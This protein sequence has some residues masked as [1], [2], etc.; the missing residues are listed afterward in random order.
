MG[1]ID[2]LLTLYR[3]DSQV[4]GLR[5]RVD[6]AETY[7]R[8]QDRQLVQIKSDQEESELHIRQKEATASN[9]ETERDGYT[10]R[11]ERLR[12][13]LNSCTT[14]KQYSAVQTEMKSLKEQADELDTQAL[15]ILE[16]LDSAR[17]QLALVVESANERVT[18]RES[19]ATD[20][21]QR[22]VDVG[23]RL[24]ELE[25]ERSSAAA[26]VPE[27]ALT[28]F[29]KVADDTEGDTLCEVR[30]VSR[31]HREYA[32]GSC[33]M[34]LPFDAVVRLTNSNDDLV[35]CSGCYRI[36]YLAESI[37]GELAK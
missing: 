18:I 12:E 15:E 9:I 29:D 26:A 11:I 21:G 25:G 10:E 23:D 28:I 27:K 20:L 19:A 4:R 32:C 13:E 17:E 3:V 6:N 16:E 33:S 24:S 8:V 35:Q 14:S 2:Q 30:E 22:R 36:L 34:E 5:T 37:K 7:L 31:R 1:L